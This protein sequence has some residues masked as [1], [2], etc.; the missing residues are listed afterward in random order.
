ML[1][2]ATVFVCAFPIILILELTG[3]ALS[4]ALFFFFKFHDLE[5]KEENPVP[6]WPSISSN[7][8]FPVTCYWVRM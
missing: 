4:S 6:Q 7:P 5:K 8:P 3:L 2:S 1:Y